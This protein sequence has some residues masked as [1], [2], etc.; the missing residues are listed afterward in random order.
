MKILIFSDVHLQVGEA[1]RP[2][3]ERFIAF[4]RSID[5]AEFDRVIILGDL[6][7]FWFEYRH[8]I[9][10]GYFDVLRAFADLR[11]AGVAFDFICGNH[12]LW[13][14]RFLRDELGFSIHPDRLMLD[15]DGARVLF[16]HGDGINPRDV[17]YRIYKR[18][19]Q[20]SP[21]VWLF[22]LLHPDWAMRLAQ[23]VSHGS[24]RMFQADDL[25]QGTEVEPLRE[26][27]KRVL[28]A[29]EAD[30]VF[31]GHCHYPQHME[32]PTPNGP[33]TYINTGD[34]LFHCSYVVWDGEAFTTHSLE[35]TEN[36][37]S[38]EVPQHET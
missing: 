19:A 10:S 3:R 25:S 36:V 18:F 28:A 5:P 17:S 12:D 15:L 6:F 9:F 11:D 26:H 35:K 20:F 31:S 7:D 14:G 23:G 22:G 21:V 30:V 2:G 4:L 29:G 13:A 38:E 33:G 32:F 37:V 8:V 27:A 34:W 16:V 24:R 1:G